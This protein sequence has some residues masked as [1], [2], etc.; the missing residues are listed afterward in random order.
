MV[1]GRCD[2][3]WRRPTYALAWVGRVLAVDAAKG[4]HSKTRRRVQPEGAP[5]TPG[6]DRSVHPAPELEGGGRTPAKPWQQDAL[7]TGRLEFLAALHR[8]DQGWLPD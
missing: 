1:E 2:V 6:S 5:E 7:P 4:A 3:P 8:L